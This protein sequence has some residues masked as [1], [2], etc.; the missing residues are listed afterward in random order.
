MQMRSKEVNKCKCMERKLNLLSQE[1][2]QLSYF[3]DF[4][5]NFT[6]KKERNYVFVIFPMLHLIRKLAV[7]VRQHIDLR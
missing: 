4:S 7:G 1:K 5:N 2:K 6:H 3:C